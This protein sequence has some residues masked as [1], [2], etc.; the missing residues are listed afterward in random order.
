MSIKIRNLNINDLKALLSFTD[1]WIGANYYSE[2]ELSEVIE[3]G[4]SDG[5]NSSFVAVT[6]A[7][8]IVGVRLTLAPGNWVQSYKTKITPSKWNLPT[9]KVG[10]FKSLFISEEYQGKGLGKELS[11]KSIE[12]LTKMGAQGI[13]C[14]S[15][16]ESPNNSSQ[17][18]L[19]K[20]DFKA[21]AEHPK[22]WYEIDYLCTRCRPDRCICTGLEMLKT[23][24]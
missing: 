14:H 3:Q 16:L 10:Y 18:Y 9:E 4:H 15:W 19:E 6:S 8:E 23:L 7:G 11:R 13:I 5:R 22:F 12:E 2:Q 20:M 17:R 21:V 1:L 24:S